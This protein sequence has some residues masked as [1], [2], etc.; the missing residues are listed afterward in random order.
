MC[1]RQRGIRS[2]ARGIAPQQKS[3]SFALPL[4]G[5]PLQKLLHFVLGLVNHDGPVERTGGDARDQVKQSLN[6]KAPGRAS[7]STRA[8]CNGVRFHDEGHI[9]VRRR[10][11]VSD[12]FSENV[13]PVGRDEEARSGCS[14]GRDVD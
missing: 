7:E 1:P 5:F 6:G 13:V 8:T 11:T 10:I 14:I 2:A 4:A 9:G 12:E 3:G